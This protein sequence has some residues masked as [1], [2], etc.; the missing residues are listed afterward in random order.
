MSDVRPTKTRNG[1]LDLARKDGSR[2][3]PRVA[4]VLSGGGNLGAIQVG[5]LKA[6]VEHDVFPDVILGCSVGAM[7]GAG[8]ALQPTMEGVESL[9][10]LWRASEGVVMPSTRIPSALQLLRKGESLHNADGLSTQIRTLLDGAHT[11]E[12]LLIPFECVAVDVESA[13]TEW[14]SEGELLEPILASA[15]LPAVYPPVTIDGRRYID[16]GVVENV[17]IGRAVELGCRTIYVLHPGPH[18]RPDAEIRRPLDAALLAYWVARNS[19]FARDLASLPEKVEA[20]VLP[21]GERPELKHDDFSQTDALVAKGYENSVKF[22]EA[23]LAEVPE[24]RRGSE[25]LRPIGRLVMSARSRNWR[26]QAQDAANAPEGAIV[27]GPDSAGDDLLDTDE[28]AQD[29]PNEVE[30]EG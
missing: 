29:R 22:L 23:K 28:V 4:F 9:E 17:P 25:L 30:H 8:F 18:G 10:K 11:F 7:N 12:D 24:R 1:L 2:R 19:Q 5:M 14:F 26:Q 16:G 6:L 3:K 27:T 15:A 13:T 20:I 21:P